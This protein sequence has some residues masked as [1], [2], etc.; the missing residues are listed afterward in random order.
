MPSTIYLVRH[1]ESAHNVSKDFTHRDPPLTSLGHTQA[2]AL[3]QSFPDPAS[4]ALVLT[5]PLTR[6]L[7][8]ALAAFSHALGQG[9]C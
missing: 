9:T 6:T 7:E 3:V 5:P 4:I 2:A 8:T 1:A